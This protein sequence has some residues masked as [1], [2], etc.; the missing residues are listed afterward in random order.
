MK[1]PFKTSKSK[2]LAELIE[3]LNST[4]SS[5]TLPCYYEHIEKL[6]FKIDNTPISTNGH[7]RSDNTVIVSSIN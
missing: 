6:S 4:R 1:N 2:S 3:K 7:T 5:L